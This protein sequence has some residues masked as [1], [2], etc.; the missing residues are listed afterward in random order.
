[1]T[2][3]SRAA[4]I[5][6]GVIAEQ[7]LKVMTALPTV[8]VVAVCD[9]SPVTA[10]T[11][12]ERAGV[13][14]WFVDATEMLADVAPDVVHVL[15]PPQ[16]HRDLTEQ[17]LNAGA[18]VLC[19]KP[20]TLTA[21]ELKAQIDRA[22]AAGRMLIESHNYGFNDQ[23]VAL[24][25]LVAGGRLGT[26]IDAD[27]S[28]AVPIATGRFAE[29][30]SPFR[31]FPAGAIHDFIT[32]LVY[33]GLRFF[34]GQSVT[35]VHS[36]WRNRSGVAALRYDEL[37][38]LIA[39]DNGFVRVRFSGHTEPLACRIAI[40]GTKGAAETDLYQPFLRAQLERPGGKLGPLVDHAVNGIGLLGASTRNFRDKLL[41]K[42][43]YHGMNV[44]IPRFYEAV[45]G[46]GETP[47]TTAD[48]LRTSE[49]IDRLVAG[50][51]A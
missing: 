36:V 8:D 43:P 14:R 6:C 49:T 40:R 4:I 28:I 19:E 2:T 21:P 33:L 42:T 12:A 3:R 44:M 30:G 47:V 38:G 5:G 51:T 26:V 11:T 34:P 31:N 48:M 29:E 37:S 17:A 24:D 7:H 15:T 35:D 16:F 23:I 18:H 20:I 22:N 9:V 25:D 41:Q 27:I 50:A 1:M 13:G 10:R 45:A 46:R 39:T 32:H